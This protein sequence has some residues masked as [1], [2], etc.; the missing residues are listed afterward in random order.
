MNTHEDAAET[1][2]DWREQLEALDT[3]ARQLV[4]EERRFH[5]GLRPGEFA[6]H[7]KDVFAQ[8]GQEL[9]FAPGHG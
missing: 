8:P 5:P 6:L 4:K 9:T 3:S 7:R 2:S 1:I